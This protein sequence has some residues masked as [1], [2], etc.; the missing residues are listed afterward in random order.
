MNPKYG[1]EVIYKVWD[2]AEGIG[3]N[4][5]PDR[6]VGTYVEIYTGDKKSTEN[7]GEVRLVLPPGLAREL[8]H[9]LIRAADNADH[10][11]K[12][13]NSYAMQGLG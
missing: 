3:L 5:G 7:F 9:A 13:Q 11:N 12:P 8:G 2:N 1:T 10:E 4:V 6:D